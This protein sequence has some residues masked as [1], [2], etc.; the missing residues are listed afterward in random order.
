MTH[1]I[2]MS[3]VTIVLMQESDTSALGVRWRPLY[4]LK[5]AVHELLAGLGEWLDWV[6]AVV[7]KLPLIV[8]WI[9]TVGTIIWICWR[10]GRFV[11]MRLLKLNGP[12][13]Q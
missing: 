13:A 6:V 12:K 5:V 4:D 11:W 3:V 1:D 9:I 10:T 7:I 2:E 8:V